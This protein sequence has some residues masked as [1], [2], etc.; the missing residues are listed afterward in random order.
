M[1]IPPGEKGAI[2]P[3]ESSADVVDA[4]TRRIDAQL[5]RRQR[6]I[7]AKMPRGHLIDRGS[8]RVQVVSRGALD[9][10]AG[11]PGRHL[12]PVPVAANRILMPEILQE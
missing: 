12:R 2:H 4:G 1:R 9:I 3:R 6:R 11:K 5:E 8:A 7:G 10:T